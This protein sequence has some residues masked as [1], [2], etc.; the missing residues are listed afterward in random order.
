MA[1]FTDGAPATIDDL[2]RYDNATDDV[3]R[4]ANID[5][6]SKLAAA[7]E[8]VGQEI[9][10]FLMFSTPQRFA[11]NLSLNNAPGEATRQRLG[12]TDVVVTP[13]VRRWHALRSL[14][15]MYRDAYGSG[16]TDRYL[17]KW[18]DMDSRARE[19]EEYAFAAG[20]GLSRNPIPKAPAA[21][22]VQTS[23]VSQ[24]TDYLVQL[25]W[26]SESGAQGAPSDPVQLSLGAGDQVFPPVNAPEGVS[27]WNVFIGAA[28]QTPMLQNAAP[29][30]TGVAWTLPEGTLVQGKPVVESVP[31]DYL[32]VERRILSRG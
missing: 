5:L 1:L 2:R 27:G 15:G 28:D 20:I 10:R 29:V 24:R 17:A 8:E 16:V 30:L 3:A 13:G 25:T 9:F 32:V 12:L 11:G 23:D 18:K 19:A 14:A 6:D 7:A 26:T 4:D 31:P 21:I 22:A